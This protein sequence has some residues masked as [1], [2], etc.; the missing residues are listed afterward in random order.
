MQNFNPFCVGSGFAAKS[1]D[2][3]RVNSAGTVYATT[4]THSSSDCMHERVQYL[5]T[6]ISAVISSCVWKVG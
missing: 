6:V 2:T 3:Q 4:S 5:S 1:A